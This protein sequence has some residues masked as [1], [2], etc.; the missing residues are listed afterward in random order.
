[1]IVLLLRQMG[2]CSIVA[3]QSLSRLFLPNLG[4]FFS[5][6]KKTY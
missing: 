4:Y 6:S 5:F 3:A 1:M 2:F